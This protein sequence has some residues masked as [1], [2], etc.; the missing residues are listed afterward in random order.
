VNSFAVATIHLAPTTRMQPPRPA[1][2]EVK[3]NRHL[4]GATFP[5]AVATIRL[6]TITDMRPP[7]PANEGLMPKGAL[8]GASIECGRQT[9]LEARRSR[10]TAEPG[11]LAP[12]IH[13]ARA[14]LPIAV[15]NV[16][17]E[18]LEE[19]RP[20]DR[21]R[22]S[23]MTTLRVPGPPFPKCGR[24]QSGEAPYAIATATPGQR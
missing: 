21:A 6:K 17:T 24:Q 14:G 19:L 2:D 1:R 13:N 5:Y 18:P 20:P 16:P 15:A 10:A 11:H 22:R 4:P 9:G 12:E 3:P 23:L 7:R 8:P